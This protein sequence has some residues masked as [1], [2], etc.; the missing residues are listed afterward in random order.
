MRVANMGTSL[1]IRLGASLRIRGDATIIAQH[2]PSSFLSPST[3]PTGN[4]RF[5][6]DLLTGANLRGGS[7]LCSAG[8]NPR[9]LPGLECAGRLDADSTGLLLWADD[10]ALVQFIIG[11]STP[12][13]KEYIVRVTGHEEWAPEMLEETL[14]LMRHGAIHLDGRKLLAASVERLNEEQLRFTLVEGRHRQIRR[15]CHVAGLCVNAI[16]RVRIGSL[17]LGSLPAGYWAPL[18]P[19]NAAS[20]LLP[21]RGP[22]AEPRAA[23]GAAP[24]RNLQARGGAAALS[25]ASPGKPAKS[26]RRRK[27]RARRAAGLAG[28][29]A[30][31][32]ASAYT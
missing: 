22:R 30:R 32:A 13:E 28:G 24:P 18:T 3:Q 16:K 23:S 1:R 31:S 29:L 21:S 9:D 8:S 25:W 2:K 20:L 17:R 26:E 5:A 10:P 14:Q 19:A 7:N 27:A 15:M 4:K 11:P 6:L 12:V